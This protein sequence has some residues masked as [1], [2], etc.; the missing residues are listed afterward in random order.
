MLSCMKNW[1]EFAY[2]VGKLKTLQRT[3]WTRYDINNPESVAD[4]S[5]RVAMLA[6][7]LANELKLD[8]NRVVKM[9]LIHDLGEAVIGDI[10][11]N[12]PDG[13]TNPASLSKFELEHKALL[14]I[15]GTIGR[16]E[17]IAY[18]EEFAAG[19]TAEARLVTGIDKLEMALQALEYEQTHN[20][21]LDEFF[22]DARAKISDPMLSSL[23]DNICA[24]RS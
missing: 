24:K 23:L 18:F 4:H 10:P 5:Y 16:E 7:F 21:R 3:G 17:W 20:I 14:E 19:K 8:Q 2:I 1:M 22:V 15:L 12:N 11:S 6:M 13:T 9:A